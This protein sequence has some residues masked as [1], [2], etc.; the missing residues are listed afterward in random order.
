MDFDM[1]VHS[2]ASDGVFSP[3]ELVKW[4]KR[5]GLT[6]LAITDHDSVDG[7]DEAV[8]YGKKYGVKVV[9]GIEISCKFAGT[10]KSV[11]EVHILGYFIDYKNPSFVKKLE[12]LQAMRRSRAKRIVAEL[13]KYD[14]FVDEVFLQQY[15]ISG[16]VGRAVIAREMVKAGYVSSVAEAFEKWL[17]EGKPGYVPRVKIRPKEAIDLIHAV[18][19]VA[20]LAHP[21]LNEDDSTIPPLAKEGLQGVEVYHPAHN[22]EQTANYRRIAEDLGLLITGGSDCHDCRLGEYWTKDE[23]VEKIQALSR[24]KMW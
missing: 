19:G 8:E 22:E 11:M 16:S 20:V 21:A 1:H 10:E 14:I 13:K 3:Q 4:A 9:P 6:G 7:L 12:E 15:A 18:G 17:G 24:N 2:T 5:I 23:T